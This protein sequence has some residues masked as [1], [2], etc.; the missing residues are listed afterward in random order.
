MLAIFVTLTYDDSFLK[1]DNGIPVLSRRDVQ[2]YHKR[3]RKKIDK[4]LN[5]FLVGEYGPTT[6]RPHYHAI[7]FGL[8]LTYS[9]AIGASWQ[10]GYHS[11]SLISDGR[12]SYVAKYSLLPS[13]L[14]EFYLKK[15][16][17]PF[18]ICS[19]G[20]GVSLLQNPQTIRMFNSDNKTY[21]NDNGYKKSLPRYY[22]LKIFSDAK[23]KQM[24]DDYITKTRKEFA[25][26]MDLQKNNPQE[27]QRKL[28]LKK[29]WVYSHAYDVENRLLKKPKI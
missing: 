18:M 14:D 29:D 9:D 1:F 20:M 15:E 23:R 5:Y 8:D 10:N 12:I 3:L 27:F 2:L 11:V 17:K 16:R 6:L 19:K 22:K 26:I 28:K 21:I 13:K 24:A 25:E 7:Y 4:K